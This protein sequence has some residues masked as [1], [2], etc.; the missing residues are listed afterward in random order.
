MSLIPDPTA[1]FAEPANENVGTRT[2]DFID[3]LTHSVYRSRPYSLRSFGL[4]VAALVLATALRAAFGSVGSH[5]P[6]TLYF[7]AILAVG[8]LAGTPAA[9][10]MALASVVIVWWAFIPPYLQFASLKADNLPLWLLFATAS[11]VTV[12]VAWLCRAALIRLHEHQRAYRT[13]A[14]ELQHR[15]KNAVLVTEAI[16]G[17]TLQHDRE[18][19]DTILGRLRAVDYANGLLTNPVPQNVALKTLI[20]SEFAPYGPDRL[21]AQ[22]PHLDVPP[23]AARHLVLIIHELVTNA[24]K[25]GALSNVGGRVAI[26]WFARAGRLSIQWDEQG[27]PRV[28]APSKQ[29]FGSR[30]ISQSVRELSGKIERDFTDRGFSCS[31]ELMLANDSEGRRWALGGG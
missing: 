11:S 3:R 24:A 26:T 15:N 29:G 19:A 21:V 5:F 18:S 31:L 2:T 22:G 25:Y 17:K 10:G 6:L 4:A 7:P 30:L 20:E 13:V 12:L 8:V 28:A 14:R 23:A 1:S 9:I 27:G 16:V